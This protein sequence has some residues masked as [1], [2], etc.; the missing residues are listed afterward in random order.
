MKTST[1]WQQLPE[2]GSFVA[3]GRTEVHPIGGGKERD[4]LLYLEEVNKDYSRPYN[5][6]LSISE[7][8]IVASTQTFYLNVTVNSPETA[9]LTGDRLTAQ[10]IQGL[11]P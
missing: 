4:F 3:F 1:A 5:W 2:P 7:N 11:T 10:F 8:N 9:K 6:R